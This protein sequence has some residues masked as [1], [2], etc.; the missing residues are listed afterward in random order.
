MPNDSPSPIERAISIALYA[1]LGLGVVLAEEL[2]QRVAQAR[3]QVE[4]A[5]FVGRFAVH[6]GVRE[7][8]SRLDELADRPAT[9]TSWGPGSA[10]STPVADE[11]P[12]CAPD[13]APDEP[14]QGDPL[15]ASKPVA[16]DVPSVD[17]L[18]LADY[19]ELPASHIVTKLDGLAADELDDIAA[20]EGAHRN[21][22]TVLGKIS[23]L[24]DA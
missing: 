5:K 20:F 14:V 16:V 4:T 19:D 21:R 17:D 22:R 11:T 18:A 15:N 2:P 24:R 9:S 23:Q 12:D 3:R 7:V 6:Q 1:P 10:D 13:R 8:R